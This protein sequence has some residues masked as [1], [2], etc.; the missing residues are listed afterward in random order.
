[1]KLERNSTIYREIESQ[2]QNILNRKPSQKDLEYYIELLENGR[3]HLS[4]IPALIKSSEEYET[5]KNFEE[6]GEGPIKT[7][8]GV[9]M[10]LNPKDHVL[11]RF[12]AYHKIWE[13]FQTLVMKKFFKENTRLI[14]IGANIGYYSLLCAT[15]CKNGSV[16]AFEP[17]PTNFKIFEKNIAIN[18]LNNIKP[19]RL[20]VS[21]S[22]GQ[23]NLYLDNLANAGDH[24]LFSNDL[25]TTP[26]NR[27]HISITSVTLDYFLKENN[28]E[29][30]I[31][32]MDIQGSEMLAFEG[33]KKTLA[34]S[35]QMILF[36]EFWPQGISATGKSP[37]DLLSNLKNIGFEIYEINNRSSQ[38]EK[39]SNEQLLRENTTSSNDMYV[40]TNLLCL[41]NIKIFDN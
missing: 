21:N 29:P 2:F 23:T 33:M 18:N 14:D 30:D 16:V 28:L 10:Y 22:T 19:Y 13:P 3:V 25:L 9:I 24:R 38:V 8:D 17:E 4:E 37:I 27:Q 35:K 32:K 6:T 5:L 34:S 11:S 40:E 31:I 36:T 15:H 20:A 26:E 12:L 1:L 7:Q 39:K 41:K